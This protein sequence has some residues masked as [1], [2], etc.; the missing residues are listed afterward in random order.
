MSKFYMAGTEGTGEYIV[1]A[2]TALG[3][4]GYRELGGETRV[5]VEP[6]DQQA[7]EAMAGLFAEGWKHPD[8]EQ[9]RF[10]RVVCGE[11]AVTEAVSLGLKAI[12]AEVQKGVEVNP[13]A[14]DWAKALV[15]SPVE[16][17]TKV[18]ADC[19]EQLA[20]AEAKLSDLAEQ[21]AEL[22]AKLAEYR[23]K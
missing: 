7:A 1:V 3:R 17:Q 4:V 15:A 8:S 2:C 9:F 5:R 14:P 21:A 16:P 12:G 22:A 18:E 13:S 20:E 19:E 23:Q 11:E 6:S 10:S